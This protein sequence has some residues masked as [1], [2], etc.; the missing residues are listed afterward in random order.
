MKLVELKK[1][2][3]IEFSNQ[4]KNNNDLLFFQSTYWMDVKKEDGWDSNIIGLKDNKNNIK[5]AT[6]ILYKKIKFIN[7]YMVYAPRGFLIDY[8][9]LNLLEEFSLKLKEDLKK[10]G[11]L[12]LKINPYVIYQTR[13]SE[14]NI[15]NKDE[16]KKLVDY[17]KKLGYKHQGFYI[18]MDHKKDLEPR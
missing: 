10:R 6:V 15:I 13:D 12:F 16:N 11:A 1:D 4:Y 8:N 5:C 2:E 9:D 3:F 17:L 7:K 14:S 18:D